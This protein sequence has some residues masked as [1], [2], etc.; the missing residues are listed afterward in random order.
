MIARIRTT[1][2]HKAK[3]G[4][5]P[6][7]VLTAEDCEKLS[8]LLERARASAYSQTVEF[9]REELE[10]ADIAT[11]EVAPTA[12]VRMGSDVKF[13]DHEDGRIH[14]AKI[15]FPEEA[16]KPPCISILS[17]VGSALIG[18]GPG[19]SICLTEQGQERCLSVLE[20]SAD[21]D[22][23]PEVSA[24]KDPLPE[25]VGVRAEFFDQSR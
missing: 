22:V 25:R 12:V 4:Q 19:Q 18:L 21:K 7:I 15:V 6:P 14:H 24:D 17:S 11:G 1:S 23:L 10:R 20:V 5:R 9:L 8:A 2:R 3:T 13:L 16:G